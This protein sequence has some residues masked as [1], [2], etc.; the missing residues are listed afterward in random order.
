LV[1]LGGVVFAE[2]RQALAARGHRAVSLVVDYTIQTLLHGLLLFLLPIY[3]ASTTLASRNGWFLILLAAAALLT[4]IDPWYR[5]IRARFRWIE[6]VLFGLGL[7]ASLNVAFPLLRVR[8]TWALVLS[9]MVSMLGLTPVFRRD[10]NVPW[11]LALRRAG[12]CAACAATVLWFLQGWIPPVPLH[13]TRATFARSV[14]R[15]EPE[16]PVSTISTTELRTWG[17]IT[18]FTAVAAPAGLREPIYHIWRKDGMEVARVPLSPISGGRPGGFRTYSRKTDPGPN[19]AGTWSVDVVT[20]H[21]QL[22]GR[23]RLRVTP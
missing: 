23:V 12:I 16:Q 4:T 13:L 20:A 14:T 11:R 6:L 19:P 10:P 15:L 1:W 18:A 5:A 17:G 7:F 21:G 22:I 2:A 3:I 9:G 8:S